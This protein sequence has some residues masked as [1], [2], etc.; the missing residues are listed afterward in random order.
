MGDA[1]QKESGRSGAQRQ[2]EQGLRRAAAPDEDDPRRDEGSRDDDHA[3][4]G[5]SLA[6]A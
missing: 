2:P 1:S 4:E 3:Q 5:Q 6:G